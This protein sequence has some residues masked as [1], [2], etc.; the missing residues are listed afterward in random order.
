MRLTEHDVQ[1]SIYNKP[2][3]A[4]PTFAGLSI[5]TSFEIPLVITTYS[6][7]NSK[8]TMNNIAVLP[9][10]G[11][12]GFAYGGSAVGQGGSTNPSLVVDGFCDTPTA[13]STGSSGE[14][15]MISTVTV[16]GIPH[17]YSEIIA[18]CLEG[19]ALGTADGWDGLNP[20][21]F[22]DPYGRQF[23]NPRII[24]FSASYVEAIPGR[25]N[26]SITMKV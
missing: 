20:L 23:N 24:D 12:G 15:V 3:L 26:V 7:P 17:L 19:R 11:S 10:Q 5:G 16:N 2:V 1:T 13:P 8:N 21:Y 9:I 18:M 25:S 6:P 4:Y 14:S 22:R